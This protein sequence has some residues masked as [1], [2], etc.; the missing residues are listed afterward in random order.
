MPGSRPLREVVAAARAYARRTGRDLTFEY[1]LLRD[2][3]DS[4]DDARGLADLVG[5]LSA[6]VNV[7]PL[8]PVAGLPW[9][10]PPPDRVT[11]FVAELRRRGLRVQERRRR[12]ADIDAACG[13]LRRRPGSGRSS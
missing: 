9:Q 5:G 11:R 13:Q 7:L 10:P 2:Q 3:N 12:G 6:L 1:V 8:N 4:L